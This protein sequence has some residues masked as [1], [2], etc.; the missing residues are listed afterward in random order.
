MI[1]LT[2]VAQAEEK[3]RLESKIEDLEE[4]IELAT[5][6]LESANERVRKLLLQV[7]WLVG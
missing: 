1:I 7:G 6:D 5:S 2:R 4:E 3:R